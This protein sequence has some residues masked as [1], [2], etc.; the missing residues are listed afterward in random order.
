MSCN[1]AAHAVRH[2][3]YTERHTASNSLRAKTGASFCPSI[4]SRPHVLHHTA[5]YNAR[6][7]RVPRVVAAHA[8]RTEEEVTSWWGVWLQWGGLRHR[9]VR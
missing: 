3:A 7:A 2:H 9:V 4:V 5:N 1:A 6:A 8:R